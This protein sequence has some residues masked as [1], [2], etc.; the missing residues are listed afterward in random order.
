MMARVT[1]LPALVAALVLIPVDALAATGAGL[2]WESTF[3]TL[4]DSL[5]GPV[6]R[7]GSVGAIA[8]TG[9]M[10]AFNEGGP[11]VRHGVKGA[12]G[13]SCATGA[14][15]LLATLWGVAPGTLF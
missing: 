6:V 5:T 13:L 2:P 1:R 8:M 14:A 10:L 9:L 11:V 3:Q 7:Y 12:F 15:S 4:A